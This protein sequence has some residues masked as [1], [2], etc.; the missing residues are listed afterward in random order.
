VQN[1][2]LNEKSEI[3]ISIVWLIQIVVAVA[4]A[5]FGYATISERIDNNHSEA[6]GLRSNQNNYV[7]PDI[8][9]LENQVI[10]LQKKVLILETELKYKKEKCND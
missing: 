9:K 7:F 4:V 10:D 3:T 6:K 8:R 1:A 5:T 2:K